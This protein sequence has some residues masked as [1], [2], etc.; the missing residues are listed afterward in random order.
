MMAVKGI[1]LRLK[2]WVSNNPE[3]CC[4][5]C[6]ITCPYYDACDSDVDAELYARYNKMSNR[7]EV[8]YACGCFSGSVGPNS[9]EQA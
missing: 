5:S 6:C 8:W 2:R 3:K 1:L 7:K 4:Q 9:V